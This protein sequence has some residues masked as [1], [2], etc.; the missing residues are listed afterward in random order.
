[1]LKHVGKMKHNG[2]KVCVIYRT[3][4]GESFSA[5]VV[6]TSSL[7]EVYHNALMKELES[8]QGQDA[9]EFG[10][11]LNMRHFP[12]G[13]NMLQYL[14]TA[15]KLIKVPTDSVIMT[16]TTSTEVPLD[17]LNLI[18]AEQR[19]CAVDDLAIR[20]DNPSQPVK[21][22]EVEIKDLSDTEQDHN[23]VEIKDLSAESEKTEFAITNPD[24][25]KKE[26]VTARDYR[27]EADRLYKE[28]AKLRKM[29]DDLDPPKKKSSAAIAKEAS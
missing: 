27:S 22:Q 21:S 13:Q 18:I 23:N 2:A 10:E 9:Y 26:L 4:P 8:V 14:H 3:L 12:N 6:G 1:M 17:Q 29:A 11:M 25:V 16:P 28:A 15:G 20:P 7:D 24:A 5:L 19:N